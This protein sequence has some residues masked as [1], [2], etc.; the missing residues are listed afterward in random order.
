MWN[1]AAGIHHPNPSV[2]G[3]G[4]SLIPPKSALWLDATGK[5][6]GPRPL[7][8]GPGAQYAGRWDRARG[9]VTYLVDQPGGAGLFALQDGGTVTLGTNP[10]TEESVVWSPD[11]R[12]RAFSAREGDAGE[13]GTFDLF[14]LTDGAGNDQQPAWSPDGTRIA[15]TSDRD[16]STDIW[17]MPAAG[18][19]PRNVTATPD[20]YEGHPAWSPD[21]A[22]LVYDGGA[23]GS[24]SP[25]RQTFSIT[26]FQAA[27]S[28]G[29]LNQDS[30]SPR[31]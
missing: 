26:S 28:R 2:P 23:S 4:L 6:F 30:V 25:S 3:E 9:R 17:V 11:G 19:A 13:G 21:G 12:W 14:R 16:G 31:L 8:T 15:F 29:T 5:R 10:G 7:V 18:G 20:G 1:Y 27:S 24:V 22:E